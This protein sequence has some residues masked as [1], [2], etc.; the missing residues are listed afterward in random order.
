MTSGRFTHSGTSSCFTGVHGSRPVG[1]V[2][3]IRTASGTFKFLEGFN[4]AA[5]EDNYENDDADD[6][7]NAQSEDCEHS[8]QDR[9]YGVH[10]MPLVCACVGSSRISANRQ[11]Q[12]PRCS[13]WPTEFQ[14]TSTRQQ[15]RQ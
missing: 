10:F 9:Q 4:Y 15:R 6:D 13:R 14:P 1:E 8:A 11:P 3:T 5:D 12:W 7:K 2:R